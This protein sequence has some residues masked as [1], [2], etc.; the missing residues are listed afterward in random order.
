M[1]LNFIEHN[2]IQYP[3]HESEGNAARWIM[4]MALHYCKGYGVDIGCNREEW[5]LP[6]AKLVDPVFGFGFHAMKLPLDINEPI[7]QFDYIFS[8]HCL[9]HVK[10]NY[11]DIL[12][13]W[14]SVIRIGGILFL[15]LP[16]KSQTYWHPSSNRKHIHSFDGSEIGD[17]LRSLGHKVFV[18]GCDANHSF[19]VICEKVENAKLEPITF[20][21][22]ISYNGDVVTPD[23][24]ITLSYSMNE[25][26]QRYNAEAKHR[27]DRQIEE[28]E[29]IN[30]KL[31]GKA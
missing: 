7:S 10:E 23:T 25:E 15:Y 18:G 6:G 16:H 22:K 20:Y 31:N 21:D 26:Y 3:K 11:Y 9:E 8:S 12:D 17:Y 14:L 4:P 30:L 5:A 28:I 13:Y 24:K 27:G 19:V 1:P 2:G 29:W